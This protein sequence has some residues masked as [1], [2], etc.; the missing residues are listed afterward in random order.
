[1]ASVEYAAVATADLFAGRPGLAIA[2]LCYAVAQVGLAYE[3]LGK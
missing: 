3:G 1:M 2:F